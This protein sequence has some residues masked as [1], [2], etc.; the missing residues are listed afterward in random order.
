MNAALENPLL[1]EPAAVAGPSVACPPEEEFEPHPNEGRLVCALKDWY[2]PFPGYYLY[3]SS[4]RQPS[5]A[6]AWG[7]NALCKAIQE[8]RLKVQWVNQD[9]RIVPEAKLSSSRF[10]NT[11]RRPCAIANPREW[12]AVRMPR[13]KCAKDTWPES[14]NGDRMCHA[15][16]T[17]AGRRSQDSGRPLL[18]GGVVRDAEVRLCLMRRFTCL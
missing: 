11:F 6:F 5:P 8:R 15:T 16:V 14:E 7:A 4:R 2:P 1:V 10:Q 13:T 9:L 12:Q 3:Y 18:Y 17:W